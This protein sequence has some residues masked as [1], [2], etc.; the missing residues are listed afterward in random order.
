MR[1]PALALSAATI[2]VLTLL[3]GCAAPATE[4]GSPTTGPTESESSG[5]TAETA[6]SAVAAPQAPASATYAWTRSAVG[7]GYWAGGDISSDGRHSVVAE[8]DGGTAG[9]KIYAS[10]GD[11][12]WAQLSFSSS[13]WPAFE[14]AAISQ[15]G[16]VILA[17]WTDAPVNGEEPHVA[18]SDDG[19]NSWQ[20]LPLP[21]PATDAVGGYWDLAASS[22][23]NTLLVAFVDLNAQGTPKISTDGGKTW[24]DAPI[25]AATWTS[26]WV[27]ADGNHMLAGGYKGPIPVVVRSD[28]SGASWDFLAEPPL[29]SASVTGLSSITASGDASTI[30]ALTRDDFEDAIG[31]ISSEDGGLSWRQLEL[32]RSAVAWAD[33]MGADVVDWLEIDLAEQSSVL[34]ATIIASEGYSDPSIG[35][36]TTA[37][38]AT[39]WTQQAAEFESANPKG[40]ITISDDASTIIV[41]ANGGREELWLG[42]LSQ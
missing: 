39:T 16:E 29:P 31:L 30:Y 3:A 4:N 5:G 19:G 23:G 9:F 36:W 6:S 17:S 18:R 28:D 14:R 1:A 7:D 41:G 24:M 12:S 13:D 11:G 8:G 32:P 38:G 34:V 2:A 10:H 37:D 25:E 42:V 33:A 35:V 27:S 15:T 20:P 22:D 40:F 26:L 21:A